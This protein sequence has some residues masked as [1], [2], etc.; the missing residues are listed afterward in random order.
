LSRAK[1]V[2][3]SI[4]PRRAAMSSTPMVPVTLK[5]CRR[6]TAI[7]HENKISMDHD[8]KRDCGTPALI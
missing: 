6:A 2:A 4:N 8:C 5:P 7:V 3:R 1:A